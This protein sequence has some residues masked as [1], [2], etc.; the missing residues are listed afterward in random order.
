MQ[1]AVG[2]KAGAEVIVHAL[3]NGGSEIVTTQ[4]MYYLK[5]ITRMRSMRQN[6]MLS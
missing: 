3:R 4:L 1:V 6:Q 5:R 2:V